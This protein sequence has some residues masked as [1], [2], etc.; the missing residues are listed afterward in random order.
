[1]VG[2]AETAARRLRA[3][4]Q[5][6]TRNHEGRGGGCFYTKVGIPKRKGAGGVP[7]LEAEIRAL[8]E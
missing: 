3:E 6:L 5:R 4:R 7:V 8:G 2:G 1:M